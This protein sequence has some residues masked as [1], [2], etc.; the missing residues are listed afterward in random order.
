M[1][2]L[3]FSQAGC[4]QN[5][6]K[7]SRHMK[8]SF[9]ATAPRIGICWTDPS[10]KA[11]AE[12]FAGRLG[13][14]LAVEPERFD[15]LLRLTPSRLELSC[16]GHPSLT[17]PT[18]VDFVHGTAGYRRR[19]GGGEVLLRALGHKANARTVVMDATGGWGDDALVMAAHGCEVRLVERHP[20]VAALL[21]DGIRRASEHPDTG[22]II[23]R[24]HLVNGDSLQV[25]EQYR[26]QEEE[27]DVIYLDPMFP[28]RSKSAKVKK[29]LQVLQL[30]IGRESDSDR[31]LTAALQTARKRVVVKR[32]A[33][34]P[35]LGE[36][37]PSHSYRGRT[38]RFDVY[39][40]DPSRLRH[41]A[42]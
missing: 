10:L 33:T 42:E 26:A 2:E 32:H 11:G 16:P 1:Q 28:L 37:C 21:Q 4:A 22:N 13:L 18:L 34:A 19:H 3:Q 25:M 6:G 27:V 35:F 8:R 9:P 24:I 20:V 23:R 5:D 31:L 7:P 30:L 14:P 40:A 39:L 38:T 12:R 15:F 36:S 29:K 17:G 41:S